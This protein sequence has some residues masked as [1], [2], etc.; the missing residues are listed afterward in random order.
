MKPFPIYEQRDMMDCGPTCL[1]MIAAWHGRHYGIEHL[2]MLCNISRDGVSL[3]GI[4]EAA[5]QIGMRSLTVRL[6]WER[7]RDEVPLPCIAHWE[8]NHFVVVYKIKRNKVYVADPGRGR[9]VYSAEEFLQGWLPY[10]S[11]PSI[12]DEGILMLLETSPSFHEIT[13]PKEGER[14]GIGFFFNYLRP[15]RR[16][17]GQLGI[18]MTVG[19]LLDLLFPFLTQSVVDYGIGN[20]DLNLITLLLAGQLMLAAGS[21]TIDILRSW[22]L[23]HA[24][25]RISTSLVA[26][27]LHKLLRLPL[28]FFDTRTA[29]DIMQR[30]N[31]HDR[32]KRFLT[33]S[34]INMAFGC[35]SFL[36]F[37]VVLAFYNWTL[38]AV[39]VATSVL[40]VG[41]LVVFMKQRRMLDHKRFTLTARERDKFVE[42]VGGVQE[43]K[44]QGMERAKRWEWEDLSVQNFRISMRGLTLKNVQSIGL[45]FLGQLRNILITFLSARAVI[46][47]DMTL[48]MMLGAQYIVGQ[49]NA[50]VHDLL[51]FIHDAQDARM[52]LERMGEIWAVKD[53]EDTSHV[54]LRVFPQSRT[55]T[56]SD[57]SFRYP[58]A[59][60]KAVLDQVNMVI[61][62]GSVTAIVGPSGSGKTTMLKMLLGLHPPGRG[63]IYVGHLPLSAFNLTTWRQRCGAVMQDGFIFPDTIARNVACDQ[64]GVDHARL[65]M[66]LQFACLREWVEELP[67]GPNTRIGDDGQ[68]L[69]GGQKQR[70]LLARAI[71]RNPEFLFLDEATSAL[72]AQ[73]EHAIMHHLRYFLPGRTAVIIAHRLSTVK[74]AD[75]I[76]VMDGGRVVEVGTHHQ[77]VRQ[78]GLYF[79]LVKNQLDLE[80][81]SPAAQRPVSP[82]SLHVA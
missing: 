13:P 77:L 19:L 16:L 32:I 20:L 52:S 66:A 51:D 2:R 72:D 49:L 7:L 57:L 71:Y 61:P 41:W 54:G 8:Q 29:G 48:G 12:D 15:H 60:Q 31:D 5:E 1:R 59:G 67:L 22:I 53:E 36:V 79:S 42:I 63:N 9:M 10:S 34:S 65:Q 74:N 24:G 45:M 68:G 78:Q 33:S 11:S 76:V 28:S 18:G 80:T 73:N 70:L 82:F 44:L 56:I 35:L 40:T 81:Q 62:E 23:L 55:L 6:P 64:S 26:D 43:I 75:Q 39:F 27:F 46:S 21:T 14:P 50:P 47:G 37:G 3:L 58:G 30:I 4:T 25:A 38:L 17:M 69:S